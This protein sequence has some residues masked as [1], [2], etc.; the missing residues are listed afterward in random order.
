MLCKSC[1]AALKRISSKASKR[2]LL[3]SLLKRKVMS[4]HQGIEMQGDMSMSAHLIWDSHSCFS[5]ITQT[6]IV[7]HNGSFFSNLSVIF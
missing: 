4:M 7:K 6:Y 5:K 1:V 3:F 2:V